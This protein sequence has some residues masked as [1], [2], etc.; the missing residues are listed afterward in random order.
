MRHKEC[1]AIIQ[2]AREWL[3]TPFHHQGRVKGVGC[4]C[5]GLVIG[6][7]EEAGIEISRHDERNY[8]MLP[9]GKK[10]KAA[11]DKYLMP[12]DIEDISGGDILLM[13]F[14]KQP[15]H[16]GIVVDAHCGGL[17]IIHCYMKARGVVEHGLDDYWRKKIVACYRFKILEK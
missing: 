16:V 11:L 15:Q 8:S 14:N 12:I 17:G 2:I 3:G 4:D 1:F 5:I 6:V 9:D 10:L 7:A 13:K